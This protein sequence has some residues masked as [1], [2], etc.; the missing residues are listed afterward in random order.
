M[1]KKCLMVLLLFTMTAALICACGSETEP[2]NGLQQT[3]DAGNGGTDVSEEDPEELLSETEKKTTDMLDP[4]GACGENVFWKLENGTLTISGTGPMYDYE[5]YV[6]GKNSPWRDD[7]TET[8]QVKE[9]VI[10]QG[11][12]RIGNCSFFRHKNLIR[13]TIPDSVTEIGIGAFQACETL[14]EI[15]IPASVIKIEKE[16]F[17]ACGLECITFSDGLTGIGEQAF[18][19]TKLVSVILP[20]SVTEVGMSAFGM[21]RQLEEVK[22]SAQMTIIPDEM[23]QECEALAGVTI[24]EGVTSIGNNAFERCYMLEYIAIP[25]SVTSIGRY[26]VNGAGGAVGGAEIRYAGSEADWAAIE[27]SGDNL[28]LDEKPLQF[29]GSN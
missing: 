13:V 15:A 24:P 26:A 27:I 1:K 12:T 11:V 9:V 28:G 8:A 16:A 5:Y 3:P 23:F 17:G 19:G 10:E 29:N 6:E 2:R 18:R 7:D 4:D 14:P 25:K 21:C 22:L 20:D